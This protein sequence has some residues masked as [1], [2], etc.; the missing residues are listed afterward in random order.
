MV[1]FNVAVL[2]GLLVVLYALQRK[3]LSFS[4]RVFAGLGLGLALGLAMQL[5]Y[6]AESDVVKRSTE[7]FAIVGSGYVRL[8]QMVAMPLVFVSILSAFTRLKLASDIG[9]IG[10]LVLIVLLTTT[11]VAA[12]IG[13]ASALGFGLHRSG[14]ATAAATA[15]PAGELE[16]RFERVQSQT[17][18]QKLL[19]LV[20]ANPFLDLTGA[21]PTSVIGV[22]L[23]AGLLGLAYLGLKE[24]SPEQAGDFARL[25]EALYGV[26][27]RLVRIILRLTP[28]GILAIMARAAATSNLRAIVS[29]GEFV[30]ASY[31]ALAVM[32]GVHLLLLLGAGL[33]PLTYARKALPVLSF[34]F[35]SRSSAATLP[36]NVSA[37]RQLGV[38]SGI[39]DVAA[40][41]ALSIG[42]NGC[43]GVY[44]AMLAVMTA[45]AAG[46]DP[47]SPAF[48][49]TLLAVVVL[50]SFGVAGL[51]GGATFA[52]LLV[53]STMNLPVGLVGLLISVEPLIDMGRTLLNVSG[54]MLAGILT[55]RLTGSLDTGVYA[56]R[57]RTVEVT[58]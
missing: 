22:V 42:Q 7:W 4:G 31:V 48:L 47:A 39:A 27:L 1:A 50:S 56:D 30:V 25:V 9:K 43:A 13:I 15:P 54:S 55:S 23:F 53:L 2:V 5:A 3:H 34:A 36:L 32:F 28:Y 20:P 12:S 44:P 29:L 33:H 14:L 52:A 6:G 26:I 11:A 17:L 41:F 40:S 8:L 37:Q 49:A 24:N 18:P 38:P 16:A 21:R 35:T 10:G 57:S 58:G 51:G 45:P 19:E 46:I